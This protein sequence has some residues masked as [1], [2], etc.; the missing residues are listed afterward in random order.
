M[1]MTDL[2]LSYK[3][4]IGIYI[5][6]P[7]C[8]GK[9]AYCDFYSSP[10]AACTELSE[11]YTDAVVRYLH[12]AARDLKGRVVDTVYFGGGTPTVLPSRSLI[13]IL[14][15]VR[16][17]LDIDASA[18][19]TVECNPGTADL[20][21][22]KALRSAGFNRLSMGAQSFNDHELRIL[23]RIHSA[24]GFVKAYSDAVSAGFDN[25]SADL[26]YGVPEQTIQSFAYSIN[27][28]LSLEPA[29]ISSYALTLEEGTPLYNRSGELTFPDEDTVA[30]MYT[31]LVST[32]ARHGYDRYEI[33]NFARK[34]RESRHNLRYWHCYDYLG[35][36]PAAHSCINGVR[37]SAV[38]STKDFILG[39]KDLRSLCDLPSSPIT[40]SVERLTVT[41][42]ATEFLMLGLRLTDGIS[43]D[44]L[45]ER[46]GIS[47]ESLLDAPLEPYIQQGFVTLTDGRLALTDKGFFV[48]SYILSDLL[49]L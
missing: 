6:I 29:H 26:M 18:E 32:L 1:T 39:T 8:L 44:E 30:E 37:F 9:C 49:R 3:N 21:Y 33:S 2:S 28:L 5:H 42:M 13:R 45:N 27:S 16:Q 43:L 36:G 7:F 23:G 12:C 35:V 10:L 17:C 40:D 24:D 19:I 15:S 46:F 38:P 14:D 41:E 47:L 4:K 22:F 34:G 11:S 31:V 48:S 20:D 25:I